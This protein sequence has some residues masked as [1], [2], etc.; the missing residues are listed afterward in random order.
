M[1]PADDDTT[2]PPR[3][4]FNRADRA[5]VSIMHIFRSAHEEHDARKANERASAGE[6][7]I[8][9]R[10]KQRREGV[11]EGTLR[12]HLERDLVSLLNTTQLDSTVSLED[13]PHV[14]HSVV[15]FGFRDLSNVAPKDLNSRGIVDSIR[16]SLM[17]YEPRLIRD[18]IEVKLKG[19]TGDKR[20]RIA[21]S[22]SAELMGDPV[23][24][25]LD[26]EAEVDLGAGK[27]NMSRLQ[28]QS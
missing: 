1:T 15:N 21:I 26:F 18:S 25:P 16:Q 23:D 13:A 22:V 9:K 7:A 8:T 4:A 19:K 5:K 3:R 10:S 27:L 11:S 2:V 14:R 24:V 20:Q 12:Q 17:D 6:V 28:V